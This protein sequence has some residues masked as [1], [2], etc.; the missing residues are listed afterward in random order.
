MLN[1]LYGWNTIT[2]NKTDFND[3][4]IKA[5]DNAYKVQ[6]I[7]KSSSNM[8]IASYTKYK[9]TLTHTDE[10]YIITLSGHLYWEDFTPL[11]GNQAPLIDKIIDRY[12]AQGSDF[13]KQA[14]GHFTLVILNKNDNSCLIANDTMATMPV[15]YTLTEN[16]QFIFSNR[17]DLLA[18]TPTISLKLNLQSIFNYI[19]FHMIPSPD[20]IYDNVYK[21]E[22]G[23]YLLSKDG[24][25]AVHNY[26]DPVFNEKT[27]SSENELANTIR[28]ILD[29]SVSFYTKKEHNIGSFLS[30]GLDSSAVSGML[31]KNIKRP[32]DTFSIGF[33]VEQYNEI[34]YARIAAKQFNTH[35]HEYFIQPE[36]VHDVVNEITAFMDE[37]FGNSSVVPVYYCAKLAKQ[38]GIN[39]LL[40]GDGGDEIFAGNKR[41]SKQQTFERYFLIPETIRKHLIEPLAQIK[42][43]SSN[44]IGRKIS[45]YIEQ[46]NIKL[47]ERLETYNFLHMHD[48]AEVFTSEFLDKI[49][50][51]NPINLLNRVYNHPSG[52]SSLNRMLYLD[53][54]HT[55]SD[56]DLRKVN[57]M[58]ELADVNVNYPMLSSEMIEFSCKVPSKLKLTANKLR[59]LYKLAMKGFLPEKIINKPKHGFGLPFG[60]WTQTDKQL[61]Q[62][63]YDSIDYL[64]GKNIF[65]D[66]F[67][68]E[69]IR[70]HQ[71]EHAGFYGEL[72]WIL[73][74]LGLWL[75]KHTNFNDS[76]LS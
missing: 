25:Y 8:G 43:F 6:S 72:I 75:E 70:K 11:A 73:M 9:P 48:P 58:C 17:L 39:T 59:Y 22:P 63:A 27:H 41:Y 67:L 51:K 45:R 50:P 56:N 23:Q 52:A 66:Q 1:I 55:L 54:K 26:W 74:I 33:P 2:H 29:K 34:E 60:V 14:K 19:Y 18:K 16:K 64:R 46:A 76:D 21:L 53:W 4:V 10:H 12:Q 40:A 24:D 15:F 35:Q 69:A 38:A 20:T 47:P 65:N 3:F 31:A 28:T 30:G 7:I 5:I 42:L 44:F 61:Q 37:P 32:A 62:L 36:D 68:D 49:D 57:M 13:L 71:E